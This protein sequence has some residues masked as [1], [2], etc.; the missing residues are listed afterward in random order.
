MINDTTTVDN[1]AHIHFS[2]HVPP[3]SIIPRDRLNL[4]SFVTK[5]RELC[6]MKNKEPLKMRYDIK[7]LMEDLDGSLGGYRTYMC[8]LFLD[9]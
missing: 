9:G 3:C 8:F 6:E 7:M 1:K 4:R 5:V 2:P